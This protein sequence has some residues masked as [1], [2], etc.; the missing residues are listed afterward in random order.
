MLSF[1]QRD[2]SFGFMSLPPFQISGI[3]L[4]TKEDLAFKINLLHQRID[5]FLFLRTVFEV[6]M[7]NSLNFFKVL[8]TRADC[9]SCT[10][11]KRNL[12]EQKKVKLRR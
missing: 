5:P 8:T 10:A 4:G 2:S 3:P 11:T 6:K 7:K 12:Q 1:T 9:F